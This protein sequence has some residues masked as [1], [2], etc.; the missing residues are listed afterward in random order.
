MGVEVEDCCFVG[1][2]DGGYGRSVGDEGDIVE[3]LRVPFSG[4]FFARRFWDDEFLSLE[5][6]VNA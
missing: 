3:F 1:D 5:I 6:L 4:L 2:D